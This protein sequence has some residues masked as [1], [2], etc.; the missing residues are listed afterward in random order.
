MKRVLLA[1]LLT[2]ACASIH[3]ANKPKKNP[4]PKEVKE[5]TYKSSADDTMQPAMYY[6]PETDKKIPLLVALHTWS[7]NHKQ[8]GSAGYARWCVAKK[9]AFIHPN[10]RGPNWT[11]QAMGSEL[12]VKDIVS[13]VDYA[14]KHSNIDENRIYLIGGSGGGYAS[15]LMAGRHP[16]IWAGVSSWCPISDLKKW[17]SECKAAKR[18]YYKHIEKSC[19]G[20]P[21][22]DPKA[23][24]ECRKRSAITYLKNAKGVNLEISTGI[25]DGH[26]GSVPISQTLEAFNEVCK[27]EDKISEEDIL[28][29]VKEQKTPPALT[30]ESGGKLEGRDIHFRRTSDKVRVTIF[31]GAHN[32]MHNPG[33]NWLDAQRKDKPAVWDAKEKTKLKYSEEDSKVSK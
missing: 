3:S 7:G 25:H 1:L 28:F 8:G 29:F 17:H 21:G 30:K 12:V 11:P 32:I 26:A 6:A 16:E 15:L 19:Q 14:K 33:L 18:G 5:I 2:S 24:E 20:V 13:A 9:W 23:D 31:E 22:Q 27:P 4:W 10:F